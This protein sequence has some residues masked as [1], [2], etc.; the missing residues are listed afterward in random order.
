MRKKL[1][2]LTL[3]L[4]AAVVGALNPRASEAQSCLSCDEVTMCC[5]NFCTGMMICY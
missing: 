2:V 5:W 3:V 4:T 1:L